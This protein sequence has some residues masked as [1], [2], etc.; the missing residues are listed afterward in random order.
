MSNLGRYARRANFMSRKDRLGSF[1][2]E[3]LFHRIGIHVG[4][5]GLDAAGQ[6]LQAW[7]GIWGEREC[8]MI[9]D[10]LW[11]KLYL[12]IE[13]SCFLERT[14]VRVSRIIKFV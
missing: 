5:P 2:E 1:L 14:R 6:V 7:N 11:R 12:V 8:E 10:K 13:H 9:L 4:E 3:A